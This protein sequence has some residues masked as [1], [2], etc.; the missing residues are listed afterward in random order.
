MTADGRAM[1][2]SLVRFRQT[3]TAF[4]AFS[5]GT[6]PPRRITDGTT[7]DQDP[8]LSPDGSQLV[9]SSSRSGYQNL[10]TAGPD[11]SMVRALTSGNAFDERPAFSP[12]GRRLA[13]VSDRGGRRGIWTMSA[14]GGIPERVIDVD[15][16]DRVVWSPDGRRLVFAVTVG[17]APAL[18]SVT[19]ADRR[20]EP[21]ATP[22][23]ATTPFGFV[24]DSVGYLE[25]FPGGEGKA[26]VSRVAFARATGEPLP[27]D[28]L[29]SLN[30]ANGFAVI[31]S[32]GRRLAALV[33][34]GGSAGSIW[35]ADLGRGTPFQKVTDLPS[36]VRLRG[37]A[38]MADTDTL[39]VGTVQRTSHLVLF[40]E[41][42]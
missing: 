35:V 19:V 41:A 14:T 24:G 27:S 29:R 15:V 36:D 12:D 17:D 39:I 30:V 4:P 23:P 7:G 34:P 22:G 11:G 13:F 5:A 18:R 1:I 37:A 16:I 33:E 6:A 28:V 26:N 8:A 42:R 10:W 32:D 9:F 2:A 25:P 40:D 20:V 3:L 38:W 21:I 31:S